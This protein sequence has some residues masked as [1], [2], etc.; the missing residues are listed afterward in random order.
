MKIKQVRNVTDGQFGVNIKFVEYG[1]A[2]L[3]AE[4]EEALLKSYPAVLKFKDITFTE[5]VQVQGGNVT[6]GAG[7]QSVTVA[8]TNKE[9]PVND[10][11]E[12]VY[13]VSLNNI[14]DSEVTGQLTTKELVAQAKSLIFEAKVVKKLTEILTT[15]RNKA[16]SFISDTEVVI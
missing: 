14:A 13:R 11:F 5:N 7:G 4:E 6:I 3:T 8:V 15:T 2:L 9:I 1:T 12:A 16:N 10:K